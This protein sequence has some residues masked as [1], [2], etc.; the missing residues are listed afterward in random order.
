MFHHIERPSVIDIFSIQS[1][2]ACSSLAEKKTF[3]LVLRND[4]R[5]SLPDILLFSLLPSPPPIVAGISNPGM[6]RNC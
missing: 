2:A 3:E 6:H 4:Q 1:T 5:F